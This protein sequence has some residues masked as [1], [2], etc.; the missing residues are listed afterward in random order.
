MA[1]DDKT[2]FCERCRKPYTQPKW[3]IRCKK[4]GSENIRSLTLS[5]WWRWEGRW[6]I[7]LSIIGL[8]I[9][10]VASIFQWFTG[11][12]K[13]NNVK[14]PDNT[15]VSASAANTNPSEVTPPVEKSGNSVLSDQDLDDLSGIFS[16]DRHSIRIT[17]N[18]GS[19][20]YQ[21]WKQPKALDEGSP[22]LQLANG[23]YTSAENNNQCPGAG[24]LT[25]IKGNLAIHIVS[26]T[27][28]N[29]GCFRSVPPD[30]ANAYMTISI[31]G[32]EKDHY[33]MYGTS[34][35]AAVQQVSS[36]NNSSGEAAYLQVKQE[37]AV[38]NRRYAAAWRMVPANQRTG[39]QQSISSLPGKVD[40]K[41]KQYAGQFT[42]GFGRKAAYL[43]CSVAHEN[44]L[45]S[46]IEQ[47][48]SALSAGKNP[49]FSDYVNPKEVVEMPIR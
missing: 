27:A 14:A 20:T 8:V 26:V 11:L 41:C 35:I 5:E 16:T 42:E 49:D 31:N 30:G 25:F 24:K 17:N 12:F 10:G 2:I 38:A 32:Q 23:T 48:A 44:M 15:A 4:C 46:G 21:S 47:Y 7:L 19:Y 18:N 45:S 28:Q 22:D 40:Q 43:R 37:A 6:W 9:W 39:L 13:S 36:N 3:Q 33:W 29:H 1:K 34:G